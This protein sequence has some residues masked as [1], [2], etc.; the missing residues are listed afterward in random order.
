DLF[1]RISEVVRVLA[2]SNDLRAAGRERVKEPG[3]V[4][5]AAEGNDPLASQ[6]FVDRCFASRAAHEPGR[7]MFQLKPQRLR[8]ELFDL[9]ANFVPPRGGNGVRARKGNRMSP[10]ERGDRLAQHS[11]RQQSP[12][13]KRIER[14]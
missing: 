1:G 9:A 3:W 5:D 10:A 12:A 2:S 4:A 14:V 13:A 7:L 6:S 8:G 11:A